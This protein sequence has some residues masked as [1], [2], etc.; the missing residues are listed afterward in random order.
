MNGGLSPTSST[1]EL[2]GH[3]VQFMLRLFVHDQPGAS[4]ASD[5]MQNAFRTRSAL[6][7]AMVR[8][9]RV[10]PR[11]RSRPTR[12]IGFI[13]TVVITA[14]PCFDLGNVQPDRHREIDGKNSLRRIE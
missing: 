9:H 4:V 13:E 1:G 2:I 14:A 5:R 8:G 10:R 3:I 11:G 12:T 7:D 6:R